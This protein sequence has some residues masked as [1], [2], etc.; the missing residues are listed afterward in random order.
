MEWSEFELTS[1]LIAIELQSVIN[2]SLPPS[3]GSGMWW[4][5]WSVVVAT[6]ASVI[7]ISTISRQHIISPDK[8]FISFYYSVTAPHL[9]ACQEPQQEQS[10]FPCLQP[11]TYL[12]RHLLLLQWLPALFSYNFVFAPSDWVIRLALLGQSFTR[13]LRNELLKKEACKY[14]GDETEPV[15]APQHEWAN[16][17][18]KL[19][20]IQMKLR[21]SSF[22]GEE[23]YSALSYFHS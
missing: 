21:S 17:F 22:L 2:W 18:Q 5:V 1:S 13:I 9:S 16:G 10:V 8:W 12:E 20:W 14:Q 23:K 19:I 6:F 15:V 7:N 3:G 11:A 4:V